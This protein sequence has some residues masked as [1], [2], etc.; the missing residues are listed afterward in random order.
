MTE[1]LIEKN[2]KRPFQKMIVTKKKKEVLMI[3]VIT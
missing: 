1:L 2:W 3:Q